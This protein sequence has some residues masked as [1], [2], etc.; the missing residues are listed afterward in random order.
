MTYNNHHEEESHPVSR[1]EF[2][3]LI[4]TLEQ[5]L[6]NDSPNIQVALQPTVIALKE[7]AANQ[8]ALRK[9]AIED[10]KKV[11]QQLEIVSDKLKM[12]DWQS[13]KIE[14]L[15]EQSK[16]QND[17][18]KE[19]INGKV[20]ITSTLISA[21]LIAIPLILCQRLIPSNLDAEI[22]QQLKHISKQIENPKKKKN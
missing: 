8:I 7:I 6:A 1:E 3:E 20:L 18:L 5:I 13:A 22:N 17:W 12:I 21:V 16:H 4:E 9:E 11:S 10:R 15:Q 2:G 14:K 19:Y